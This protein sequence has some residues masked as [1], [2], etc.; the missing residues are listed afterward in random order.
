[1]PQQI[2]AAGSHSSSSEYEDEDEF[3]EESAGTDAKYRVAGNVTDHPANQSKNIESMASIASVLL[4]LR[5]S[6]RRGT[7]ATTELNSSKKPEQVQGDEIEDLTLGSEE[8]QKSMK[9]ALPEAEFDDMRVRGDGGDP[10]KKAKP[11]DDEHN[12]RDL[13]DK[14]T[15]TLESLLMPAI[16]QRQTEKFEGEQAVYFNG[17]KIN[18]TRPSWGLGEGNNSGRVAHGSEDPRADLLKYPKDDF[19]LEQVR[20]LEHIR[21]QLW[22][23][24]QVDQGRTIDRQNE[25]TAVQATVKKK[26]KSMSTIC[27]D[28]AREWSER[29]GL[30]RKAATVFVKEPLE[31]LRT[32][33]Q[34]F[35]GAK[36][37]KRALLERRKCPE[38]WILADSHVLRSLIAGFIYTEVFTKTVPW[39]ISESLTAAGGANLKYG[40]E[41]MLDKGYHLDEFFKKWAWKM[42]EDKTFQDDVIKPYANNL[43][44]QLALALTPHLIKA[45]Q[46]QTRAEL[47]SDV[48]PDNGEET[49]HTVAF[50]TEWVDEIEEL[51]FDALVFKEKIDSYHEISYEYTW[52]VPGALLDPL[53]PGIRAI[54]DGRY[55]GGEAFQLVMTLAQAR[56]WPAHRPLPTKGIK[57]TAEDAELVTAS[58]LKNGR[59]QIPG[60]VSEQDA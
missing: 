56:R 41:A 39:D 54:P 40:Q 16:D 52:S 26:M 2:E 21:G 34:Q 59:L 14:K 35:F 11:R 37:W 44:A 8:A 32:L 1:M 31:E 60:K 15:S 55:S 42:V 33:Y 18:G 49:T 27:A 50:D 45:R 30:N 17:R 47:E 7:G 24:G 12:R 19:E 57:R 46:N 53:W 28:L 9:R 20:S 29:Y 6:R 36:H 58:N 10:A 13:G 38:P 23:A 4:P 3:F 48:V 51:I 25:R 5:R 43:A 22:P